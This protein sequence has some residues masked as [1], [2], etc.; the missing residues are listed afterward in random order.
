MGMAT[1]YLIYLKKNNI[2][3]QHVESNNRTDL[4]WWLL[5]MDSSM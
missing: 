1:V 5:C 3:L 4:Y 2:Y